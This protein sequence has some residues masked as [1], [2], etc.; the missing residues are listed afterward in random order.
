M[1]I[2]VL[3]EG[4]M[5]FRLLRW[6]RRRRL[7]LRL[8]SWWVGSEKVVDLGPNEFRLVGE[9]VAKLGLELLNDVV[10]RGEGRGVACSGGVDQ[11]L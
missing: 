5:V 6:R 9:V 1:V 4:E 3:L 11:G 10:E 2:R 7:R 8:R